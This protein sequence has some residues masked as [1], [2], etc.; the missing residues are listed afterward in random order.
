VLPP[1][2]EYR[3]SLALLLPT[4]VALR[5]SLSPSTGV[6]LIQDIK[7]KCPNTGR[8]IRAIDDRNLLRCL[9]PMVLTL[10]HR[11]QGLTNHKALEAVVAQHIL[12]QAAMGALHITLESCRLGPQRLGL[13]A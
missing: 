3:R 2:P 6:G 8:V 1:K 4:L 12:A 9:E 10:H 7:D 5:E 11:L 13:V